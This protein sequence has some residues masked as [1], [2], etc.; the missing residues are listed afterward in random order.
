MNIR[1]LK[2]PSGEI[3]ISLTSGHSIVIPEEGIN[4]EEMFWKE[5]YSEGAIS[6]DMEDNFSKFR[7]KDI[8]IFIKKQK[9]KETKELR[10]FLKEIFNDPRSFVS[11][12][13]IPY[14]RRVSAQLNRKINNSEMLDIWEHIKK[15][16]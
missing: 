14:V 11:K 9:S 3:Y 6:G 12:Q 4:V 2:S 5:A 8:Q 10:D 15:N 7:D 1:K 16:N 13:G